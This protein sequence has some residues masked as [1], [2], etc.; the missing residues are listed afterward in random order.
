M[1]LASLFSSKV[2]V[3][4]W[5]S[6]AWLWLMTCSCIYCPMKC[7]RHDKPS[8]VQ[9][10]HWLCTINLFCRRWKLIV[11]VACLDKSPYRGAMDVY[12]Q[13]SQLFGS[14]LSWKWDGL[15]LL[16]VEDG[17]PAFF[18]YCSGGQ[19][20]LTH[21][22]PWYLTGCWTH[23]EPKRRALNAFRLRDQV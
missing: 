19:K 5:T 11:H 4:W 13:L 20:T 16:V 2:L 8:R 10:K 3:T 9:F 1:R 7:T 15:Y 14:W 23:V 6:C 17:E 18:R 21:V 22:C 12:L